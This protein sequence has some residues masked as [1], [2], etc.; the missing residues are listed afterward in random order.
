MYT[1]GLDV[2]TFALSQFRGRIFTR[3]QINIL[4]VSQMF[5]TSNLLVPETV[6]LSPLSSL[7]LGPLDAPYTKKSE[8]MMLET[9]P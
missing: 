7:M 4:I 5:D 9:L 8:K 2:P 3:C 6:P 1:S